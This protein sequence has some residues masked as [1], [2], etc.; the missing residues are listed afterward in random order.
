MNNI[1]CFLLFFFI[2]NTTRADDKFDTGKNLQ[3]LK[4]S[5][6]VRSGTTKEC[7]LLKQMNTCQLLEI[8]GKPILSD[9]FVN[10]D[11]A[12]PSK[13]NPKVIFA[14]ESSGGNACCEE[15]Y[16]IDLTSSDVEVIKTESLPKQYNEKPVVKTYDDFFTFENYGDGEGLL[17]ESLWKVFKYTYGSSQ[18]E[19][20]SSNPK[21]SFTKLS[22]KKYP[23]EILD[24]KVN[25]LPILNLL[26]RVQ[27]LKLR[28]KM[29]VQ[30][31]IKKYVNS[32]YVGE[33]CTPHS[34][35][36]EEGMF[37]LDSLKKK[38]WAIYFV[39]ENN[40]T[41]GTFFG[42]IDDSDSQVKNIFDNW[43]IEHKLSWNQFLGFNQFIDL[44]RRPYSKGISGGLPPINRITN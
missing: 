15:S 23:S 40:K 5:I 7:V 10:I 22:E 31:E 16:L 25:R 28:K 29:G 43:L 2:I 8:N 27:F 20:L 33:G 11:A 30:F 3:F 17:G 42:F 9:Y 4:Y 1:I 35:G 14:T 26:G 32:I 44:N 19:I 41:I 36:V 21:Y 39:E 13:S 38:A 34:C 18:I 24:D 12:I 6:S 37:V